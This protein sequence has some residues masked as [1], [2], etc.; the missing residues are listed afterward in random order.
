MIAKC[1]GAAAQ[2]WTPVATGNKLKHVASGKCLVVPGAN[3]ASGTDLT[4]G[5]CDTSG[6]SQSWA[7]ADETTYVYGP[8]GERLMSLTAST[9]TLHLG[10]TTVSLN[11]DK[12]PNYTERYYQ[13]AGGPTV[14][15]LKQG[16]GADQLSMQVTD[17][18]GT[19]YIDVK[20]AVGNAVRFDKTDP[21]GVARKESANWPSRKGYIGG[22][23]D[24]SSGLIHL[25]AREYDPETG[26]F[27]SVD[28][29]LDLADPVQMNGYVYC[30]NNPVTFSDPS[31]LIT[32]GGSGGGSGG[33]G[34]AETAEEAWANQQLN[35]SM[36]DIILNVGWAVF[37]EFVGWNDVVS[38]FSR[39][40]LWACGSLILDAIPWTAALTKGKKILAAVQKTFN[41][42]SAWRSAQEKARKI[43][44]AAKAAREAARKAAEAAKAAA[45]KAAQLA[46][47][48]AQEAATRAAKKAAEKTGNSV[49][50]AKK[51][52][53]KSTEKVK[54]AAQKPKQSNAT[55]AD[56][57][58]NN[59][60]TPGTQVLM[61]DGSSKPIEQVKNG[62]T[63]LARDPET[64][65]TSP[66]TVT[67]EITGEGVKDLAKVTIDTDGTKGDN[68]ASVTATGNH[69]FWV[70]AIGKW[71]DATDLKPG[72][73]LRTSAGT[74]VQITAI[75][76]WTAPD[77]TVHNLTVNDLHTYY[78]LAGAAPVLVHN[79]GPGGQDRA[80]AGHTY[81]GGQYK[82]LKDPATGNN[83]AG[84]EINHVPPAAVAEAHLGY[85]SG[86]A[87]RMD[88]LDH[89]AVYSTGSSRASKAWRMWQQELVDGGRID[90]AV[91]MDINDIRS[92]F[93]A[94]YDGAIGQMLTGMAN[95]PA[96]QALRGIPSRVG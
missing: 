23:D 29:V 60:F 96:Y 37:K 45:K 55:A 58:K 59:S 74:F 20:L 48:R 75:T 3:P 11:T 95:D 87:V 56:S 28:P 88:Y 25:G 86:P 4:L 90:E 62:D 49:Q 44:A 12:T 35:T 67:A 6:A 13:Q 9:R 73:W 52:T 47:K 39:G 34:T 94:K 41:A 38:C 81:E 50:K 22:D 26:R 89:R 64:G 5:T 61:A 43:I 1:T 14:L 16:G 80:D 53:A 82:S 70:E 54:S 93:G 78:V 30:E 40:D 7:P 17:Q 57:C 85:R 21:F 91:Q 51:V 46:K 92:R 19:A 76:R 79:C 72:E 2:Q 42:I 8:S 15:R 69:P 18:N 31:G 68:T 33:G 77:A 65:V 84:T 27:M 71:L 66:E 32:E 83:Y 24:N 10:D 36:S 63:V